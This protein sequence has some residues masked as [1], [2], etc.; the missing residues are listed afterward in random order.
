MRT[1]RE[2]R[3]SKITGNAKKVKDSHYM[4]FVDR[5]C[6]FMLCFYDNDDDDNNIHIHPPHTHILLYIY[7]YICTKRSY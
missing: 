4:V 5:Y 6:L 3:E 2:K 1:D 7:T